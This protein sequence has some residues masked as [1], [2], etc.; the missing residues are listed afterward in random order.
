MRPDRQPWVTTC[1]VIGF[2][3]ASAPSLG[4]DKVYEVKPVAPK[5]TC[6]HPHS[7][8]QDDMAIWVHPMDPSKSTL[9]A[10]DKKADR[11]FVYDLEG[12]R[13]SQCRSR[14][15]ATSTCATDSRSANTR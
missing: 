2:A 4:Q 8:D 6:S 14:I 7:Q 10:S 3:L 13:F 12:K 5:V 15:R 9:I 1:L 11:L